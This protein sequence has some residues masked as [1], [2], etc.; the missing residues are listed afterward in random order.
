VAFFNYSTHWPTD[1]WARR[2]F[3]DAWWKIYASDPRWI[4]PDYVA[5]RRLLTNRD[6]AYWQRVGAQSL[7]LEA[8]PAR[9]QQP[10][11]SATQPSLAGAVFEE[12]VAA[13]VLLYEPTYDG[14]AYLSMLHCV[15][16]EETLDRLLGAA[17]EQSME[18]GC[19]RLIGPTGVIPA[20]CSG[21]LTNFFHVFPP[22]HTPYNP[23]YLPDLLAAAMTVCHQSVLLRLPVRSSGSPTT[24]PATIQ[25]LDPA[26]LDKALLSLLDAALTPHAVAP[27]L[28]ADAASLLI[29]W[30]TVHPTV[31]WVACVDETPVGFVVVQPDLAPV[32]RRFGGG[33][34][35]AM[36]WVAALA[37]RRPT[38][39]GR[40]LFGAVAPEIRRRGIGRQLLSQALVYAAS[41]GWCELS[42]GPFANPSPAV[43]CLQ[44][45][46]ASI[47]QCYVLFEWNG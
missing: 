36:R 37:Q 5:W 32:M 26:T 24:G 41:V 22:N 4:P 6:V 47:E 13:A 43:T 18:A 8:L 35:L 3:I 21:V 30:V 10:H 12:P 1:W 20:W 42:C 16:D 45:A 2:S 19:T 39:R 46:G 29:R 44:A 27:K 33:R 7:Y 31:G 34:P 25:P 17:I 14:T 23:P 11:T 15:N 38:Q 9:R 40:L 28:A